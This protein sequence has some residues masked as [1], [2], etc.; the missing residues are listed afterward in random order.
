MNQDARE[1]RYGKN[2]RQRAALLLALSVAM[3]LGFIAV[4]ALRRTEF[5][6][7][8]QGIAVVLLLSLLFTMRAQLARITYRCRIL[9]DHVH[10]IAPFVTRAIPWDA[11]VEVRRMRLPQTGKDQGW[12]CAVFTTSRRGT[13]LP[14]YLF[15]YQLVQAEDALQQIVLHTPHARHTNI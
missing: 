11:I 5:G 15:D 4:L 10:V 7:F 9:P 1:Y 8:T 3:G 2:V 6:A 12:A 14:T 13:A